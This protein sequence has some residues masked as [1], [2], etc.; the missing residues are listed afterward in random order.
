MRIIERVALAQDKGLVIIE[1]CEKFYL[2]GFSNNNVEILKELNKAEIKFQ[3]P[4][5][6]DKFLNILNST[7]KSGWDVKMGG[8][9]LKRKNKA[10]TTE[11]KKT[12]R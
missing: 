9:S 2:V 12:K 10:D 11:N 3:K 5:I 8:S 6:N 1:I 7:I 4:A